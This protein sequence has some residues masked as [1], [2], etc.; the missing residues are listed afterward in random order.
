MLAWFADKVA[1]GLVTGVIM[2]AGTWISH[3]R[4]KRHITEQTATTR[5]DRK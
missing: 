2:S 3:R 1:P 5:G 4:L